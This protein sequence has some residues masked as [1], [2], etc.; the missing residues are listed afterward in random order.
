MS[1]ARPDPPA[2]TPR[3]PAWL[4][5]LGLAVLTAALYAPA[6]RHAFLALD[7][8]DYVT[9]NP[10]VQ[11]GLGW[12]GIGWAFTTGHAS[13]WHPL[14]WLSHQL[15]VS[16][17]GDNPAGHHAGNLLLHTASA[18][19][20]FFVLRRLTGAHWRAL[21]V[22]GLFAWHPLRL[23]SVAWV[24]ERKDV[25]SGF[26]FLLTL[27]SY[28]R[29]VAVRTGA[30]TPKE[31]RGWYLATALALAGG[32]M[33]K[34]MLVTTP[35]VLLLLDYW[36]LRRA[37]HGW[38]ALVIE[39]LPFLGL[40]VA[41]C[42]VTYLVQDAGGAV[43][44]LEA[45]PLG[46]RIANAAVSVA[47]YVRDA[48]WPQRLSVFYPHPG[49]WP[50][51][52][53]VTAAVLL[54][55]V[56]AVA[57]WRRRDQ[58]ALWFGWCWFGG[59]LVPTLGLVQVGEQSRADRYTYLPMIG[60]SLALVWLIADWVRHS[61]ARRAVAGG[62]AVL[63]LAAAATSTVQ[64]LR[65]WR[66]SETLFAR[67]LAVTDRNFVAHHALG[68]H[69]L[70]LG[71]LDGAAEEIARAL[72]V[73]PR[74]ADALN[75]LGSVRWQQGRR[76]EAIEQ[77]RA[78]VAAAPGFVLARANLGTALLEDGRAEEAIGELA[79]A[80]RARPDDAE[81]QLQ[82]GNAHVA[83]EETDAA[84]ACFERAIAL[85][86]ELADAHNN[87]GHLE[88]QAGRTGA[89]LAHFERALRAN[90]RHVNARFNLA[91]AKRL[92]GELGEAV[93][94]Y[95]A[96]LALVPDDP[97]ALL[98]LGLLL[99]DRGEFG[100]AVAHLSRAVELRPDDPRVLAV[101][102]WLRA[103]CPEHALR[104]GRRA[105]VLA[106]RAVE[107]TPDGDPMVL[108]SLAAA[109]AETGNFAEAESVARRALQLARDS[110]ATALEP[111]LLP[112]IERYAAGQPWR[113]GGEGA[114]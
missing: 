24:A 45:H 63:A 91:E 6:L 40:S 37:T 105:L 108:R 21:V 43:R 23:E 47:F 60:V 48:F 44:T 86:P 114:P 42:L 110:G 9:A 96:Y 34:P 79:R 65:Y 53:V 59:M 54:A 7:D 51:G 70:E 52:S 1:E 66:D 3:I 30:G 13:N 95:E 97:D 64:Q 76:A 99:Q 32:L 82:L 14:T 11:R 25:L 78:A 18:V 84:A 15:D 61:R 77:F 109:L 50:V 19:C 80:A 106:K 58:P 55:V 89:A 75:N 41:S 62:L 46:E 81:I 10:A 20:L 101:L 107:L 17:W 73:R 68:H 93:V 71:N 72:A 102:A 49:S 28:A 90:P 29:Y 111:F 74:F 56:T 69:R 35:A 57:W 67:A 36:P 31:V 2:P 16:L 39:K 103:T 92:R 38:R 27:Y 5:A 94:A 104:D 83:L 112:P 100:T 4:L 85:R 26:L 22:A 12:A 87:F 98:A 113:E 33:S 88:L 8:P